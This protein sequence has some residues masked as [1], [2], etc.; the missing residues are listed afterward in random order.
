[1]DH[2]LLFVLSLSLTFVLRYVGSG[3]TNVVFRLS[4]CLLSLNFSLYLVRILYFAVICILIRLHQSKKAHST[5]WQ[6]LLLC[7]YQITSIFPCCIL[8]N[9]NMFSQ[10]YVFIF[11]NYVR[12]YYEKKVFKSWWSAIPSISTNPP[13]S[14]KSLT[15]IKTTTYNVGNPGTG[16]RREK[17][18]LLLI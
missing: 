6:A 2:C 11:Y 3:Y 16:L 13:V 18:V 10:W 15:T 9:M 17:N 5:T 1:M 8:Q 7:K 4:L 14:S 12:C